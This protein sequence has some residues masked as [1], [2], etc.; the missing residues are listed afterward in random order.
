MVCGP[1]GRTHSRAPGP[2]A[3][4]ASATVAEMS[5]VC[6]RCAAARSASDRYEVCMTTRFAAWIC[7]W[8]CTCHWSGTVCARER[9]PSSSARGDGAEASTSR[10]E[11]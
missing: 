11:P 7:A 9:M 8:I 6:S 3:A 2:V 10:Y 1:S 5:E 4:S